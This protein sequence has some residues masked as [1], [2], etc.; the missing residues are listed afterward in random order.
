MGAAFNGHL[1]A[2]RVLVDAK[3]DVAHKNQ[4]GLTALAAAEHRG[5]Q[6]VVDFLAKPKGKGKSK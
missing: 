4:A 2:V 3:A 1:D 6:D 5:H